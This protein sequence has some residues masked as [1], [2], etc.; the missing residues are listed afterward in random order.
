MTDMLVLGFDGIDTASNVKNKLLELNSQFLLRLDQVVEVVR[1]ADGQV[2]IKEDPKLTGAG[3]LGGAFWGLLVGLIFF[4][5]LAGLA[6]GAVSGAILGH[7]AKYGLSKEFMKKIDEA[8]QPGQSGLFVLAEDVKIDRVIP[9]LA[10][11]HPRVLRTSLTL[12]QEAQLKEAF[13]SPGSQ[14]ATAV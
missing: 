5:P 2:K 7:F 10:A 11:Y 1:K 9:M 13:G 3:A 12:A 6:V 14:M 8:I 4:V